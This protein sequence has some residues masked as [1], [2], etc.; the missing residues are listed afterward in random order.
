MK[1][2]FLIL[3]FGS[4]SFAQTPATETDRIKI[5]LAEIYGLQIKWREANGG[6][7]DN[8]HSLGLKKIEN[9]KGFNF[10]LLKTKKPSFK[11]TLKTEKEVW[12]IDETKTITQIK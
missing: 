4:F 11:I 7:T 8:P 6:F 12:D 1:I 9:C 5:C 3:F 2:I 10:N